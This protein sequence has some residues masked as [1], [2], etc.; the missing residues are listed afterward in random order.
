MLSPMY[1]A[2]ESRTQSELLSADS[3]SSAALT[4]PTSPVEG[5][6]ALKTFALVMK[7]WQ[8]PRPCE[9]CGKEFTVQYVQATK[10]RFCGRSCSAKW[11]MSQPEYLAK[12]H[13]PEVAKK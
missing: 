3:E 8:H 13:T 7:S 6:S 5:G 11:R 12:V 2:D 1:T 10:T 9:W 4:I